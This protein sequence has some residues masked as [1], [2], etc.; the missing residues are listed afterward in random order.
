MTRTTETTIT[1]IGLSRQD[2]GPH[3]W[4]LNKWKNSLNGVVSTYVLCFLECMF[5]HHTVLYYYHPCVIIIRWVK[6]SYF[7]VEGC[8]TLNTKRRSSTSTRSM[9]VSMLRSSNKLPA[10]CHTSIRQGTYFPFKSTITHNVKFSKC[11][12]L[13]GNTQQSSWSAVQQ[14]SNPTI[15]H[16]IL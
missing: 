10:T 4:C 5:A 11:H 3:R 15:T 8:D 14:E 12:S 7:L 13:A 2:N 6:I 16:L 1:I 9:R